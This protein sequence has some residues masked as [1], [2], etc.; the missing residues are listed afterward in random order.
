MNTI[1]SRRLMTFYGGL[2]KSMRNAT[3]KGSEKGGNAETSHL[4]MFYHFFHP[5]PELRL[6]EGQPAFPK[7]SV[8]HFSIVACS[9]FLIWLP[10]Q[11]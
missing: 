2:G 8:E 1:K 4:C 9:C 10:A 7:R 5:H 11:C 6:R 3:P